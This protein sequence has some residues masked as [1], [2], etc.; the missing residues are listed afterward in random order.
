MWSLHSARSYMIH[1]D[2]NHSQT[3]TVWV[4]VGV[5][6]EREKQDINPVC[7]VTCDHASNMNMWK[8]T[9]TKCQRTKEKDINAPAEISRRETKNGAF[10]PTSC[11]WTMSTR[12]SHQVLVLFSSHIV[13]S[14]QNFKVLL[15]FSNTSWFSPIYWPPASGQSGRR[16]PWEHTAQNICP[17]CYYPGG[18]TDPSTQ[19][20]TNY[21]FN[22]SEGRQRNAF[23]YKLQCWIKSSKQQ[24]SSKQWRGCLGLTHKSATQL[25][26]KCEFKL[27]NNSIFRQTSSQRRG[28]WRTFFVLFI[29]LEHNDAFSFPYL[30][31]RSWTNSRCLF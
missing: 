23:N 20:C 18:L 24:A 22:P 9:R 8:A 26:V 28:K 31:K 15:R 3:P 17:R 25:N 4:G 21:Y 13:L 6:T 29:T 5:R 1:R 19:N 14:D 16:A 30:R 11:F 27:Q 12:K 10:Q 2:Q 7:F